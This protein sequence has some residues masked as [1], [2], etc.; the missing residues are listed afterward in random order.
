MKS[1]LKYWFPVIAY[2][3]L[4]FGLSSTS[5]PPQV[6]PLFPHSDK[7]FHFIEYAILGFLL[8][9]ALSSSGINFK[10]VNVR[11]IAVLLALAYA[12]TDEFHQYF[13]PGRHADMLDLLSDGIG[14]FTGQLFFRSKQKD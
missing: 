14:A 2:C 3:A 7:I 6:M 1:F 8:M 11:T 10:T 5:E 4:I 9:R 13:V 12:G